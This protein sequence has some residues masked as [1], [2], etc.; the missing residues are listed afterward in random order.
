[1]MV[2]RPKT[3]LILEEIIIGTSG[4][5]STSVD[6]SRMKDTNP[7]KSGAKMLPMGFEPMP[8]KTRA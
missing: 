3:A 1:M 2:V 7:K 8:I 4:W 5:E 6:Y